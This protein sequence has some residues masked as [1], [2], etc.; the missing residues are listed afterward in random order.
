LQELA[1]VDRK[2]RTGAEH[3]KHLVEEAEA[4]VSNLPTQMD[5]CFIEPSKYRFK[6]GFKKRKQ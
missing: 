1:I 4:L 2:W 6:F 3:G 5:Q